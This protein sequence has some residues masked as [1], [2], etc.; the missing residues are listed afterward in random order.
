MAQVARYV[1]SHDSL[2]T[3]HTI[4][5]PPPAPLRR[6]PVV[7]VPR[8]LCSEFCVPSNTFIRVLYFCRVCCV[9]VSVLLCFCDRLRSTCYSPCCV[10]TFFLSSVAL[11]HPP[12]VALEL[13]LAPSLPRSLAP[14]LPLP[15]APSPP[16]PSRLF[17][18]GS[19]VN[20]RPTTP[21]TAPLQ[22]SMRE[23]QLQMQRVTSL[24]QL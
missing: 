18:D 6:N 14:S 2:P 1:A 13:A 9:Y 19:T 22:T 11:R 24:A 12:S 16:S 8:L 10:F 3:T 4:S 15:L 23:H 21:P 17:S 20:P 5:Q 7:R